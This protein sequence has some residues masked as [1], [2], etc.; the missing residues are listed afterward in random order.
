MEIIRGSNRPVIAVVFSSD[1]RTLASA[2]ADRTAS[3]WDVPSGEH[4]RPINA[5]IGI[6]RVLISAAFLADG[7]TLLTTSPSSGLKLWDAKK[8]AAVGVPGVGPD[9]R[10]VAGGLIRGHSPGARLPSPARMI[11]PNGYDF[12]QGSTRKSV[13]ILDGLAL[14]SPSTT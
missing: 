1:V 8:G 13:F 14:G 9:S 2:C 3:L 4:I 12:A 5:T 10:H 6:T 7:R 11:W